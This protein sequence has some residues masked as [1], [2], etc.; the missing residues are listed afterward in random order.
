M[1]MTGDYANRSDLRNPVNRRVEFRGQTYG[2]GAAQQRA[3]DVVPAG[4]AAQDVA[5]QRAAG[6]RPRP[7]ARPL[8]R[9][10]ERA[11]EPV[12]AGAPFGPG[13][14]PTAAGIRP[15]IVSKDNVELQLETLYRMYPTPGVAL[16]LERIRTAKLGRGR[17]V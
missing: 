1:S 17:I 4:S 12:T 5:A 16:L 6:Q 8:G 14:G 15:R 10:T 13:P 9:P 11:D 3:Q 2:E 7:G